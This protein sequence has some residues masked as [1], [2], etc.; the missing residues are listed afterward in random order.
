[1]TRNEQA[2]EMANQAMRVILKRSIHGILEI[3]IY[4]HPKTTSS[5]R[6]PA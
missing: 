4:L 5:K 6:L 2:F 1:M 3:V